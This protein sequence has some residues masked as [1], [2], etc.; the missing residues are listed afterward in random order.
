MSNFQ[1]AWLGR[2]ATARRTNRANQHLGRNSESLM[3]AADHLERE[4]T[5]A[6][7][8]LMNPTATADD[9]DQSVRIQSLLFESKPNRLDRV[10]RIDWEMVLF[11]CFEQRSEDL[12]HVTVR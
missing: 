11:L 6:V 10:R 9:S 12:K 4:R 1:N 8:P 5:L 7:H 2:S 3:E